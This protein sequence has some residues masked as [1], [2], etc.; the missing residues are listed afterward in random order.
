M[1]A[2]RGMPPPHSLL[3]CVSNPGDGEA[4]RGMLAREGY[5]VDSVR[6]GAEAVQQVGQQRYEAALLDI[7]SPDGDGAWALQAML[8]LD[9]TLPLLVF[10]SDAAVQDSVLSRLA[11]VHASLTKPYNSSEVLAAVRRAVAHT[12]LENG[13]ECVQRA[14]QESD[15]RFR[16][17]VEVAPDAIVLADANGTSQCSPRGSVLKRYSPRKGRLWE[18]ITLSGPLCQK[19]PQIRPRP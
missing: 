19:P 10:T 7:G 6:D 4:L 11:G 18:E 14:L 17:V 1:S 13:V 9:P 2:S 8:E 16:A 3:L 5:R 15:A 12:N